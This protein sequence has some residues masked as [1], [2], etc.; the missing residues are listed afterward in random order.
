[1]GKSQ[2]K[3]EDWLKTSIVLW[4]CLLVPIVKQNELFLIFNPK[5][6][7]IIPEIEKLLAVPEDTTLL[8]KVPETF[9]ARKIETGFDCKEDIPRSTFQ[10]MSNIWELCNVCTSYP[11]HI[12]SKESCNNCDTR[13]VLF[14]EYPWRV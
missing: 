7:L 6:I 10:Y 4:I 3:I 2:E 11:H 5:T 9:P 13:P 14:S 12:H 1:M 8:Q